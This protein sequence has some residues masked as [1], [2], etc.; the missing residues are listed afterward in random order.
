MHKARVLA[1][2][3]FWNKYHEKKQDG[4]VFDLWVPRAWAVPII[5]EEE[6]NYNTLEIRKFL[7]RKMLQLSNNKKGVVL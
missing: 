3:Y 2:N 4:K 7:I 1:L 6:Y 5:G